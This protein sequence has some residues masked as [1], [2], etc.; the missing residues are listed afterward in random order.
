MPRE[1]V[2][3]VYDLTCLDEQDGKRYRAFLFTDG[4]PT[5]FD[6]GLERTT[7][8]LLDEIDDVGVVPERLVITHDDGDHVG[9]FDTVVDQYDVETLVPAG[10]HLDADH[11]P[12][13]EYSHGDH[14]GRFTAVHTPGH[15]AEH[16]SLI[17]EERGIAVLGDAL[18]GA[19]QRGFP[20]G[21]FHLPPAVYSENLNQAEESLNGLLKFEFEIG[22]V[23]HGSSVTSNAH[24]ALDRYVNFPGK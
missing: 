8:V 14:I 19:D 6:T 4:T 23:F 9:G 21:G 2:P 7:D 24:D 20:R 10:L 15:T 22:L 13:S 1:I 12:D 17:D 16:H 3:D 11:D 5:L 18:S